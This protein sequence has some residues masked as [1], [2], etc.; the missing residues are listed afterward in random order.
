[1]DQWLTPPTLI[2]VLALV[3]GAVNAYY[4]RKRDRQQDW[5]HDSKKLETEITTVSNRISE[6]EGDLKVLNKQMNLFWS[7]VEQQMA[8]KFRDE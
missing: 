5:K 2:A 8:K 4:I 1:M 3:L 7:T 6:I